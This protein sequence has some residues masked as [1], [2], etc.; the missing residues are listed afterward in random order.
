MKLN[1]LRLALVLSFSVC[2]LGSTYAQVTLGT[3]PY[4]EN[5]DGIGTA[6][7][8]GWTVRT[9]ATASALGTSQSLTI[10]TTA[11]NSTTGNF[12]NSASADSP[13]T[14][15][16]NTATQAANTD[17]ALSVRQTGSFGDAGAAF[18][19]QLANTTGLVDFDLSFS[20]QQL[21]Q[22]I[23]GRTTTWTVDY[24]FGATPTSFTSVTSSPATVSTVQGTFSNAVVTAD[25]GTALDNN[26][27]PVHPHRS[28]IRHIG[29]RNKT[30]HRG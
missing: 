16:D 27:G 24:G 1:T 20:I 17:R 6:L 30:A 14:A 23:A 4:T 28:T 11:W 15:T 18:V 10:A 7:P 25:F 22:T 26:A 21:H 19:L 8:T 2:M 12:H 29:Y 9:G 5:F 13:A 3:S